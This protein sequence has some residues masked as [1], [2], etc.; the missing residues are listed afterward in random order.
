[1]FVQCCI[2]IYVHKGPKCGLWAWTRSVYLQKARKILPLDWWYETRRRAI[3]MLFL[4]VCA[5]CDKWTFKLADAKPQSKPSA[6]DDT[7]HNPWVC[8]SLCKR[9]YSCSR[10][11]CGKPCRGGPH[12]HYNWLYPRKRKCSSLQRPYD[13]QGCNDNSWWAERG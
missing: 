9:L 13:K 2:R 6:F 4:G 5:W 3:A 11:S 7:L 12:L 1:M 10:S 8:Q